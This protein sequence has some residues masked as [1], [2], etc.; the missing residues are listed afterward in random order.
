MVESPI[1][2]IRE[3]RRG[4]AVAAKRL[5]TEAIA[6]FGFELTGSRAYLSS[7]LRYLFIYLARKTTLPKPASL[8]RAIRDF[9]DAAVPEVARTIEIV[10]YNRLAVP[11]GFAGGSRALI[12]R[13]VRAPGPLP[14]AW[15]RYIVAT[16]LTPNRTRIT[17]VTDFDSDLMAQRYCCQLAM[18][19]DALFSGVHDA[20]KMAERDL[21]AAHLRD[22]QGIS[23]DQ[24]YKVELMNPVV[25]QRIR[26]VVAQY[27]FN[28]NLCLESV[29]GMGLASAVHDFH[30]R[31]FLEFRGTPLLEALAEVAVERYH[32]YAFQSVRD[33]PES[34][35]SAMTG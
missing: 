16:A 6:P 17:A 18:M 9:L 14:L 12:I 2:P 24:R 4:V 13:S 5:G 22:L 15:S 34:M 8:I 21:M 32:S 1:F 33:V 29:G 27:Y 7:R 19:H 31:R 35:A 20:P 25:V 26:A 28:L 11:T 3:W 23:L 10:D 30:G